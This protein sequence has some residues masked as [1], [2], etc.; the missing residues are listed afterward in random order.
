[1]IKRVLVSVSQTPSRSPETGLALHLAKAHGAR[2]TGFTAVDADQIEQA[3]PTSVG[4]FSYQVKLRENNLQAAKDEAS[5]AIADFSRA[6]EETGIEFR[7]ASASGGSAATLADVWRFQDLCLMSAK[8]WGPG[9]EGSGDASS[10]LHLVA[11]GLRPLI[12][13][14]DQASSEVPKKVMIALSGSLDSAKAMKHFIQ[15]NLFGDISAHVVVAGKPK[16][17]ES[18]EILLK[19]ASD[20]LEAHGCTATTAALDDSSDRTALLLEEAE[21]VGAGLLVIGSSY[22]RILTIERFGKHAA[23]VLKNSSIPIFISH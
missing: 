22:K 18:A 14:P 21:R 1:M 5:R 2:I 16:S 15:L 20:Y 17:G 10:V 4:V 8:P 9:S 11:M 13:V 3:T 12:A 6:V 7:T 19:D 23:G